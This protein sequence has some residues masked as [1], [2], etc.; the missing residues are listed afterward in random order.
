MA[1]ARATQPRWSEPPSDAA[2]RMPDFDQIYREHF[3][4]VWHCLR[5]LGVL[6]SS[7]RDAA[8]DTFLVVH[9]RL[10][11]FEGRSP[12]RSWLYGIVI[13]VASNY[14]RTRQRR[15]GCTHEL[16][17]D[18]LADDSDTNQQQTLEQ[19]QSLELVRELLLELDVDKREAF[20]LTELHELSVVEVAAI[21][22]T[23][24]GTIYARLRA[25]RQQ[26]DRAVVRHLARNK[27][28]P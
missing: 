11:E 17:L 14:R 12:I 23:N 10:P 27:R 21:L 15:D 16:D 3:S 6:E 9:R 26:F 28:F 19:R 18:T 22:G 25:A 5:R 20:E 13:R 7:L 8:Q 24:P 1:P 2:E 4:F